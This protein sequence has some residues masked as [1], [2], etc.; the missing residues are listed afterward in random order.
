MAS[1]RMHFLSQRPWV[2]SLII[3]IGIGGWLASGDGTADSSTIDKETRSPSEFN[4]IP[5]AKVAYR[6]FQ[7]EMTT[8]EL[9]L[10]GR[11]APH[12]EANLSTELDGR[13]SR[14]PIRQGE[15][16]TKGQIIAYIDKGDLDIRLER[17]IALYNVKDKEFQAATSLKNKGLQGEVAYAS[18]EAELI[19]AKAAVANVKLLLKHSVIKAPFSGVIDTLYVE[20]GE[21]VQRGDPIAHLIDLK[22][23]MITAELSQNHIQ[24]VKNNQKANVI[25]HNKQHFDGHLRYISQFASI[26]TNT[27]PI[28]V[29][30]AN[31]KQ[32]IPAGISTEIR[33]QLDSQAAIKVTPATLALDES[34]NLGVKTLVSDKVQFIPVQIVK[35]ERNGVWLSGLGDSVDIITIGQGFV[36]DGDDV[37][38]SLEQ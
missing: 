8:K 12:R 1:N 5:L 34:G 31:E 29:E 35:A 13:I 32:Q 30:I 24:K 18:A 25:L 22:K 20:L 26:E 14:V 10:Y 33:I 23:L 6:T 9:T 4:D 7:S 19:E 27:F 3:V 17:A 11:T 37:I 21:F 2:I 28:E 36:R 38:A 15:R 16:V